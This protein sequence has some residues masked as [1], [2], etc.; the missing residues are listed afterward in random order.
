MA[1]VLAAGNGNGQRAVAGL[2]RFFIK[3][4]FTGTAWVLLCIFIVNAVNFY[5]V[6]VDTGLLPVKEIDYIVGGNLS[7]PFWSESSIAPYVIYRFADADGNPKRKATYDKRSLP[8]HP[9]WF[10]AELRGRASA[11]FTPP[12]ATILIR[13]DSPLYDTLSV[14]DR[15]VLAFENGEPTPRTDKKPLPR[16]AWA[17]FARK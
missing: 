16:Y 12:P 17:V 6:P 15:Y 8:D 11:L 7:D 2:R 10:A 5:R 3:L 14:D 4:K 13:A 1:L 9:E